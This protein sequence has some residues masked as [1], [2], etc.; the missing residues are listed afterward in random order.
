MKLGNSVFIAQNATLIGDVTIDDDSFILYGAV[1]RGD[2]NSVYIGKGTNIQDNV[3]VHVDEE[4][5]TEIGDNVSVGHRAIVHGS[6]IGSNSL[7]G[8]G[9][10]LMSGSV[11]EEG[12]VVGAG[13]LVTSG[14]VVKENCL[15]I[16]SPAK[17]VRCD[18]SLREM[19]KKNASIYRNLKYQHSQGIHKRYL[20]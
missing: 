9:A 16:G 5:C 17:T 15:A 19:A 1:I 7:I 20:P 8:M 14:T 18:Q 13:A 11:I 3:V 12:S 2:Q 10:I 4:N 6:K